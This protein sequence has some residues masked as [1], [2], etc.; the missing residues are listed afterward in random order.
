MVIYREEFSDLTRSLVGLTVSRPWQGIGS[1]LFLELGRLTT[2]RY[3]VGRRGEREL[4][5][6]EA[7]FQLQCA[8]RFEEG[9][10][11][12]CGAWDSCDHIDQFL[13]AVVGATIEEV[14]LYGEPP[15]LLIVLSTGIRIRSLSVE[16]DESAWWIR[17]QSGTLLTCID[18][19]LVNGSADD[20]PGELSDA[21]AAYSA[22]AKGAAERWS[23][24]EVEPVSGR[25]RRCQ[26]F[27][28]LGGYFELSDYGVCACDGGPLDGRAVHRSSG[29]PAFV[30]MGPS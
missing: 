23:E 7:Q 19:D 25:C 22:Q 2:E 26:R 16:S 12:T 8:W 30:E 17:L 24:P 3:N 1:V 10:R 6:G 29:C 5:K 20:G 18:G 15:D 28:P 13:P 21:E 9:R 4:A 11:V 14:Q 27:I